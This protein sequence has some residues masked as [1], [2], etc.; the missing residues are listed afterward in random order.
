L[1]GFATDRVHGGNGDPV[2]GDSTST[3]NDKV[4]DGLV[5]EDLVDV[6]AL[7]IANLIENDG[8]V[9]TKACMC[10]SK[11]VGSKLDKD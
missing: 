1:N 11:R 5:E 9:E 10:V 2:P 4:A 8:V 3:G 7:R 6:F